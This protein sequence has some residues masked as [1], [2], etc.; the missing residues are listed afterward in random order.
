M[1]NVNLIL[2]INVCK[3]DPW[4]PD[5]S[6]PSKQEI[7]IVL[8]SKTTFWQCVQNGYYLELLDAGLYFLGLV[9][10]SVVLHLEGKSVAMYYI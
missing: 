2:G 7:W 3:V 8:K 4:K 9:R 1:F 6:T 10:E 5:G